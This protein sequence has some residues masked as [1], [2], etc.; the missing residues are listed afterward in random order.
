MKA[1]ISLIVQTCVFLVVFL[2]G[3]LI[4]PFHLK[5][6]AT[7]VSA[8][9]TRF[10]VPDG[11][12]LMCGAYVLLLLAE[13][14]GRRLARAGVWT[15]AAFIIALVCGFLAKFGMVTHDSY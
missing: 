10:F 13:L 11:L 6:F 14:A 12:I 4:D 5:W 2:A 1:M 8:T 3:S 15:T 9:A 7:R